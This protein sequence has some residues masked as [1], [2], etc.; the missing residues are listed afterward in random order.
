MV[1]DIEMLYTIPQNDVSS[2]LVLDFATVKLG[3][4]FTPNKCVKQ[5]HPRQ[6]RKFDQYS[7]DPRI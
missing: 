5:R 1:Q 7:R 6:H 3:V 4:Q 2:F